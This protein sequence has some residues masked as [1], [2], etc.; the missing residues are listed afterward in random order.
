M[1]TQGG[2][3]RVLISGSWKTLD[4]AYYTNVSE[5]M[6]FYELYN[7]LVS[8]DENF[9]IKPELARSWTVSQDGLVW[10]FNLAPNVR[11]HDGTPFN[12]AAVKFNL[13]RLIN[14]ETASTL[15]SLLE[16]V[17][18]IQVVDNTTIRIVLKRP[19]SPL[20]ALLTEGPG[21]M[22]SPTGVQRWGRDFGQ[23]PIGTGPFQLVEWSAGDQIRLKRFD[24][25]WENGLPYLDE[26]VIKPVPDETV[27]LATLRAGG[28]DVL[29]SVGPKDIRTL[30]DSKEF[31]AIMYPGTRWPMIRLSA[32]RP[33]FNNKA[34]RQ[35]ISYAVNRDE[36]IQAVYFGQARPAYGPISP[37][38]RSLY[39]L[40]IRS[41]GYSRN[42]EKA[43]QKLAEGGQPNGFRFA[44]EIFSSPTQVRMAELIKAQVAE[45][46]IVADIQVYEP[47]T[48]QDRLT[49]KRYE[50]AIGSWTPRPDPDGTIY[51]HFHS[52]GNVNHFCYSNPRVD[53]LLDQTRV[54][55][56][57][58]QRVGAFREAEQ[59]IVQDTP[60]VFLLFENLTVAMSKKA[61]GLP[62]IPDTMLR[63]KT[64]WLSH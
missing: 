11:F 46:D 20:L 13:D 7:P 16:P 44:L 18:D 22:A 17:K 4:P 23:H 2:T 36:L 59:L 24:A 40:Q 50:A 37:V 9:A 26:V 6:I 47:T 19:F 34:L 48:F 41:L 51:N 3:L 10:T 5:R 61:N 52:Q 8:M 57:G 25:Y 14:P 49:A 32:C 58:P 21:F 54:L 12:A 1:P 55:P 31:K 35:A 15:R 27:R 30:L 62:A 64:V 56:P 63:F 29:D 39:N 60:W 43:H 38:Y 42:L 33:P 45:A 28:A 53:E